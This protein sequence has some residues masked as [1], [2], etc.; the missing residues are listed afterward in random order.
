M[1]R[2]L[3]RQAHGLISLDVSSVFSK[4]TRHRGVVFIVFLS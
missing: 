3:P 2:E 4:Q 1:Y